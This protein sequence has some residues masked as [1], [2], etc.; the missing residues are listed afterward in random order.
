MVKIKKIKVEQ[1]WTLEDEKV[2]IQVDDQGRPIDEEGGLFSGAMGHL[3]RTKFPIDYESWP[4]IPDSIK[5]DV[6]A[7]LVMVCKCGNQVFFR[8]CFILMLI[9]LVFVCCSH[10]FTFLMMKWAIGLPNTSLGFDG[11]ITS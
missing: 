5:N 2:V 3:A 4:N 11:E 9:F 10:T 6:V 7:R 1:V 8:V